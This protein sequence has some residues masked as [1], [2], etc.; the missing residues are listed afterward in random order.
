MNKFEV[1]PGKKS[2]DDKILLY[3][4]H[5]PTFEDVAKMCLF[6]MENEE[7]LYPQKNGYKGEK[8]FMEYIA[9]TFT[10]KQVPK[11]FKYKPKK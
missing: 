3:Y 4:G 10:T 2:P 1:I 6:F 11:D 9:K 8:L 7:R 5:A